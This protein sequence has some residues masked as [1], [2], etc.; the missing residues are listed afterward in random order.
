MVL[1]LP[2]TFRFTFIIVYIVPNNN[3]KIQALLTYTGGGASPWISCCRGT[4]FPPGSHSRVWA[5]TA[6]VWEWQC[7][8]FYN[9]VPQRLNKHLSAQWHPQ[10]AAEDYGF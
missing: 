3:D 9:A 5:H 4:G 1:Y 2:S 6:K 10:P 8:L 7:S